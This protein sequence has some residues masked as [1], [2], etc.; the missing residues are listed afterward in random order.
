MPDKLNPRET[1][2]VDEGVLAN[3]WVMEAIVE[4]LERQG[5]CTTYGEEGAYQLAL[6]AREAA[7]QVLS[8]QAFL[9]FEARV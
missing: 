6:A 4:L 7:L 8:S 9:P 1:F 2:T 3:T 5:L